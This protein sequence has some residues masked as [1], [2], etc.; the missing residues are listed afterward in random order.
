MSEPRLLSRSGV[1]N[2]LGSLLSDLSSVNSSDVQNPFITDPTTITNNDT[3]Q[4]STSFAHLT[5]RQDLSS[6]E[7]IHFRCRPVSSFDSATHTSVCEAVLGIFPDTCSST[8]S[9]S[10]QPPVLV[11][12]VVEQRHRRIKVGDW[13]LAINGTPLNWINLNDVLSKYHSTRKLRLTIRHPDTYHSTFSSSLQ[14][15]ITLPS[16][17]EK[18]LFQP[19]QINCIHSVLYYEKIPN[20]GFKLLYQQPKQKDIFFAAGG[21]FPTLT[22]LMHDMNEHDSLLRSVSI[23]ITEQIIPICVTSDDNIHYLIIIYPS[24]E[25]LHISLL[26]QHTR[27]LVR[28]M[29]FLFGSVDRGLLFFQES[30]EYFFDVFFYRLNSLI[31]TS[32]VS[33]PLLKNIRLIDEFLPAQFNDY[34]TC[35]KLNLNDQQLLFNIDCLLTQLECQNFNECSNESDFIINRYRRIFILTGSVLFH[36]VQLLTSHLSNETTI[37]IYRFLLHY[38]HLNMSQFYSDTWHLL[39]FKEIFPSGFNLKQRWF[40]IVGSHSELTLAAVIQ[41][42]YEN[43][44]FVVP[45]D[46]E[47]VQQIKLTLNDIHTIFPKMIT[48]SAPWILS[49]PLAFLKKPL[50]RTIS[51]PLIGGFG[52]S[53]K[54]NTFDSHADDTISLAASH[55]HDA[56]QTDLRVSQLVSQPESQDE[57]YKSSRQSIMSSTLSLDEQQK[58]KT[59][60]AN[61]LTYRL[62]PGNFSTIFYYL[63]FQAIR[64]LLIAPYF[65]LDKLTKTTLI[66]RFLFETIQQTCIYIRKKHFSR[67]KQLKSTNIFSTKNRPKYNEIGCQFSMQTDP[68]NKKKKDANLFHFWIVAKQCLQPIEHEFFVCYHDSIAQNITELAFTIGMSSI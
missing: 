42:E 26:E 27:Q 49:S 31:P 20:Q 5:Y 2:R 67:P 8:A 10:V 25:N 53:S 40:L 36:R 61:L 62:H 1:F 17:E 39:L 4:F 65:T 57:L 55:Y 60:Q 51:L 58:T 56:S 68:D 19:E 43:N 30:I 29:N 37:D 32:V 3:I 18:K 48:N 34:G 24:I 23:K 63:D 45:P 15:P 66:E 9:S 50:K 44:D 13:L 38:G 21:V 35:P 22:Q 54:P 28:L 46:H 11:R 12:G 14:P 33:T 6:V 59:L 64:G 7:H 52:Q 16:I 47:L 41:T